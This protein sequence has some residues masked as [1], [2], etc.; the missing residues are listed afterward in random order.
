MPTDDTLD[1]ELTRNDF[2]NMDP[3]QLLGI[4][5]KLRQSR[6]AMRF[7]RDRL[8]E[9]I[10]AERD[11]LARMTTLAQ[12]LQKQAQERDARLARVAMRL[13]DEGM[14]ERMV[15]SDRVSSHDR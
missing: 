3:D 13:V 1:I 12:G 6:N 7:E 11:A 14:L 4:H 9:G 15:S 8:K 5:D 10:E 2:E